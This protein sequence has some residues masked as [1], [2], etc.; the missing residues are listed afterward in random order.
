MAEKIAN[1]RLIKYR[2]LESSIVLPESDHTDMSLQ[3]NI[4]QAYGEFVDDRKYAHRLTVKI[5]NNDGSV[6]IT[7]KSIGYFEFD[8][9]IEDKKQIFAKQN[10][11]AILF[12]YIRAHIS[13]LT[14]LSGI[15]PIILPTINLSAKL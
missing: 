4:E 10:A 11:P 15:S 6:N 1:F 13:A 3:I 8:S 5:Q 14:G 12:P 2:I 7:V 9:A